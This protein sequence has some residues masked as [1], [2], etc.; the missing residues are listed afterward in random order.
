[1]KNIFLTLAAVTLLVLSGCTATVSRSQNLKDAEAKMVAAYEAHAANTEAAFQAA[2]Q[3]LLQAQTNYAT[4]L[5]NERISDIQHAVAADPTKAADGIAAAANAN[6]TL[7]AQIAAQNNAQNNLRA[8]VQNS[9]TVNL[10]QVARPLDAVIRKAD[11]VPT[12][13]AVQ[14]TQSISTTVQALI[15]PPTPVTT[16]GVKNQPQPKAQVL[17]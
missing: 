17:P 10:V 13:N 4:E 7:Q 5:H 6:A 11:N 12:F 9:K 14:A 1:M 2:D 8:V 3:G 16:P 15:P